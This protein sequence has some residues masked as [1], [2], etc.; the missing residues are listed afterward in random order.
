VVV[1]TLTTEGIRC[2]LVPTDLTFK[3][4]FFGELVAIL[5]ATWAVLPLGRDTVEE[6]GQ[7]LFE[8]HGM[9]SADIQGAVPTNSIFSHLHRK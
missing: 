8:G 1:V 9:H 6:D 5:A 7:L 2:A 4:G 3:V